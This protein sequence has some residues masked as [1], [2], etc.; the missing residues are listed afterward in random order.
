MAVRLT[1][2]TQSGLKKVL[3][4]TDAVFDASGKHL[5]LFY[6]PWFAIAFSLSILASWQLI[7]FLLN[8]PTFIRP[9]TAVTGLIGAGGLIIEFYL[10]LKA[11]LGEL[12]ST[13]FH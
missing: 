2:R 13:F 5:F 12:N 9:T 6:F 8:R 10:A 3:S 4:L 11:D 7:V 1:K